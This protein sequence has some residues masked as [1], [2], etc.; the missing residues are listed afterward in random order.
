MELYPAIDLRAGRCVRLAQGDFGR[1]TVYGTDPVERALAFEAAG[2]RWLHVVDLDA[3]RTGV[4]T[5]RPVVAAIAAAVNIS[6][7]SGGGVRSVDDAGELLDAGVA[8]VVVGTAAVMK[9][10]FLADIAQR[11]PGRVA[12]AVDHRNGEVRVRGWSEASGAPDVASVVR[13]LG[14]AGAAAVMVTE[15]SATA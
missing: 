9:E 1:E 11:W 14:A 6:V 7:Q 15:I 13:D 12:A 3:A 8:R 2:A 5:N 10:G 4:A